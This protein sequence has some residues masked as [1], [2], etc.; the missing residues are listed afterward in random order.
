[1]RLSFERLISTLHT[2]LT[3]V[4]D[5]K[6]KKKKKTPLINPDL[7]FA[8][9]LRNKFHVEYAFKSNKIK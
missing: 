4:Q 9:E 6:K 1:M 8:T 3:F 7:F 2:K 5:F